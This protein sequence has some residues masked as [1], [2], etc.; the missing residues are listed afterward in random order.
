MTPKT[1]T[2]TVARAGTVIAGVLVLTGTLVGPAAGAATALASGHPP[3]AAKAASDRMGRAHCPGNLADGL[4]STGRARQLITVEGAGRAS[5]TATVE[6]WQWAGGCWEK[7]GGPWAAFV[8]RNGFSDH[9]HEGDGTTPDGIFGIGPEMYGTSPN[10]G[11]RY[12][13][14]RLVC[15]DWWDEDPTSAQYNTFQ[16]VPCGQAPP[17]GGASEALWTETSAYSSFAV[18]EY[19]TGPVVAYAGSAIFLHPAFGAPTAGCVALPLRP[20]DT[21]LRWLV[22]SLRPAIV[23][24]PAAEMTGTQAAPSVRLGYR[25]GN[26]TRLGGWE[27]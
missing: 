4:A 12:P 2:A 21:V 19:N 7:A 11:T 6:T 15:G 27:T 18:I 20:L 23:M 26:R 16:H 5:P 3:A 14:H 17:F 1:R 8:G 22:P 9:H 13:Y 25:V 24:G 10:P